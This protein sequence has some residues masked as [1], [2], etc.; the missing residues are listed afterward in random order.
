MN[1]VES[2]GN[3][4][5]F[6]ENLKYYME[7]SNVNAAEICDA[8]NIKKSTF[9]CWV[10]AAAYPRIDK[11]ELLANYFNI[12]KSAL[13]EKRT[14]TVPEYDPDIQELVVLLPKLTQE[15]KNHLIQ[16][17]RLFAQQNELK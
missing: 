2:L 17:A 8:L 9:S 15:Q 11:I 13:V 16:T 7:R 5:V 12:K 4:E 14:A 6:A 1:K 10:T 3:K